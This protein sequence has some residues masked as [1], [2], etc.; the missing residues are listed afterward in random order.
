MLTVHMRLKGGRRCFVIGPSI[1]DPGYALAD[2]LP[3]LFLS[4]SL[5]NLWHER[6]HF[7]GVRVAKNDW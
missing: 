4:N 2:W 6:F 5:E 1:L 3:S 7:I